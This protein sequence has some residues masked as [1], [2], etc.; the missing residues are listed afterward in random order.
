MSQTKIRFTVKFPTLHS[1]PPIW[2]CQKHK[3]I[4]PTGEKSYFF[5]TVNWKSLLNT[6]FEVQPQPLL[7]VNCWIN[8]AAWGNGY[9][10]PSKDPAAFVNPILRHDWVRLGLL[11]SFYPSCAEYA[12]GLRPTVLQQFTQIHVSIKPRWK[13]P[14]RGSNIV[15][16]HSGSG[17]S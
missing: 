6:L 10:G 2:K 5:D 3:S 17:C 1:C 15:L 9:R 7:M 14:P 12:F 13:L 16:T 4:K 11:N 8:I